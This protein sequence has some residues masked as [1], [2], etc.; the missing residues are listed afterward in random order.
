MTNSAEIGNASKYSKNNDSVY[1]I[2][3]RI[4]DTVIY[5]DGSVDNIEIVKTELKDLGY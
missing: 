4:A 5:S 1:C 3:S 2:I